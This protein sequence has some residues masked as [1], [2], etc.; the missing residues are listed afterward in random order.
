ME[1]GGRFEEAIRRD[2]DLECRKPID[3]TEVK[4]EDGRVASW[5]PEKASEG[6][7]GKGKVDEAFELPERCA[8]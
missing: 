4:L 6:L 8:L 5:T 3:V 1:H 2:L 7:G